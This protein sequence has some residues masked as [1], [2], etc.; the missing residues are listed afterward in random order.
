MT[1]PVVA[2]ERSAKQKRDLINFKT[3]A[4]MRL[5][6]C[7]SPSFQGISHGVIAPVIRFRLKAPTEAL[8]RSKASSMKLINVGSRFS[9]TSR[10]TN[11]GLA[12][13][14]CGDL[15]DGAKVI[16]E[17][18]T[19]IRMH[20]LTRR[21]GHSAGLRPRSSA[22]VYSRQCHDVAERFSL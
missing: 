11:R 3:L 18:F 10:T 12:T 7:Q 8:M 21:G 5:P 13:W 19:S 17:E 15:M 9:W 16:E 1:R 2:Q 14:I 20:A 22:T 6:L 4:S